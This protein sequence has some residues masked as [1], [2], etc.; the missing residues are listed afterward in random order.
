MAFVGLLQFGDEALILFPGTNDRRQFAR[1]RAT[2][3]LW[4]Y[5]EHV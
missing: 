5:F 4:I 2:V 1:Q 3:A